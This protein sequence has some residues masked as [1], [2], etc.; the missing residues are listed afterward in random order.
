MKILEQTDYRLRLRERPLLSWF[1][2]GMFVLVPML[3]LSF[4]PVAEIHCQRQTL[5]YECITTTTSFVSQ[6]R[7]KIPLSLLRQAKLEDYIDSEGDRMYRVVLEVAGNSTILGV[8]SSEPGDRAAMVQQINQFLANPNQTQLSARVDDRW[9]IGIIAGVFFLVGMSFISFT[10]VLTVDL[11]R[12][13]GTLTILH[14]NFFRRTQ[15][16]LRLRE[17]S[18]IAIESSVDSDGDRLYRV[19]VHLTSG[20]T[21]PLRQYY[22]SGY[23]SKKELV[24]LLR[25]FLYL[26]PL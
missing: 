11:D 1:M 26:P 3:M 22:S 13:S 6:Q 2:G 18:D 12:G 19:V 23:D 9:L 21:V 20:E 24:N 10:P 17:I 25:Q 15:K 8:A 4:F 7:V 14:G 16:E 5:P